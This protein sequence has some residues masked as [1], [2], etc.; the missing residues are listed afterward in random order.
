MNKIWFIMTVAS[1]CLLLW[2]GPGKTLTTMIDAST[3]A[4]KH[5]VELCAVYAIWLGVLELVEASGLGD[6]LAKFL[7][8]IIKKLFKLDDKEAER[9]IALNLSANMLGLG[10][11]ATPM[12]IRAMKKLDDGSGIATPA[13]I[14]LIV[15][16][17]TSIQLLPTTIIGMR[18]SSG[19]TSP[20][21]II[22][23]TLIATIFT[24]MLGIVLVKIFH[25]FYEKSKRKAK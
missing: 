20:E 18:A 24:C 14:M 19:S 17:A 25:K 22:L 21:D 1:F 7:H 9:L 10:N 13:I 15:L 11:A 3:F 12:G 6:K 8:P 16:N 5:V 4:L 2:T 23:P